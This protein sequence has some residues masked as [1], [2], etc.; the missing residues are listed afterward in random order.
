LEEK[1]GY[2]QLLKS[3]RRHPPKVCGLVFFDV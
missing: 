1:N 2:N 3:T